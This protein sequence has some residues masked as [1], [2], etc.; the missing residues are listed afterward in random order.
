MS[1]G[2]APPMT[3]MQLWRLH[4]KEC[5]AI[6]GIVSDARSGRLPGVRP[7]SYGCGYEIT[8]QRSALAAMRKGAPCAS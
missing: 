2:Y 7:K 1:P 5:R 6:G 8:D 3:L 4:R